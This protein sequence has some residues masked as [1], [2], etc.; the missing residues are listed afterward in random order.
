MIVG[1]PG[2]MSPE[3]AEGAAIG[4]ASDVFSLGCVLAFAATGAGQFGND[5][6]ATVLYRVV[7][8]E[9]VLAGMRGTLR[10]LVLECLAKP[11]A[12]RPTLRRL[13]EAMAGRWAPP[14][15]SP[16][17]SFWPDT[18][19]DLVHSYQGLLPPQIL[20]PAP[21]TTVAHG[22]DPDERPPRRRPPPPTGPPI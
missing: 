3:Q 6:P 13:A 8:A 14:E 20:P 1:T 22:L 17:N 2:F 12:D 18:L 21:L 10:S 15:A 7:H 4:P 11:A 9:P 19:T 5:G 16:P